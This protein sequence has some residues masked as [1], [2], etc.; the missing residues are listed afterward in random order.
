MQAWYIAAREDCSNAPLQTVSVTRRGFSPPQVQR[1]V[2]EPGAQGPFLVP[3]QSWCGQARPGQSWCV[4]A[5]S[6]AWSYVGVGPGCEL[7]AR[8]SWPIL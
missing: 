1:P 6:Y 2:Y 5:R 8:S 7:K 4:L 3:G